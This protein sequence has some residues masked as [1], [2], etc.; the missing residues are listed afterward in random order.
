MAGENVYINLWKIFGHS[1]FIMGSV[2]SVSSL[3]AVGLV[4]CASHLLL[5]FCVGMDRAVKRRT[6]ICHAHA[7][8][9]TLCPVHIPEI[10]LGLSRIIQLQLLIHL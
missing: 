3:E 10:E 7:V 8:Y 9:F 5:A 2:W 4:S 1:V 6:F